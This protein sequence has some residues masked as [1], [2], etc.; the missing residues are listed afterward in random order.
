[1]KITDVSVNELNVVTIDF[2]DGSR[3]GTFFVIGE[4]LLKALDKVA[5]ESSSTALK[6]IKNEPKAIHIKVRLG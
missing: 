5:Q 4:K 1:M 6:S 2:V 3:E